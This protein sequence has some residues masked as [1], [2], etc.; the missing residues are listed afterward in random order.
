MINVSVIICTHNPRPDYLSRVLAAL[1]SQT[2]PMEQW[3]LLVIDNASQEPL[4]SASWDLSWHPRARLIREEELGLAMARMRGM[5]EAVAA[6]FVFVDDDN[7]LDPGYLA[8]AFR[9]GREWPQLGV[10]GGS[11]IHEYEIQPSSNLYEF[12]GALGLRDVKSPLWS[13][14]MTC[15]DALPI[16][17]GLCVRAAVGAAYA[18]HFG[19]AD[20]QL[21]GRR[22]ASLLSGEDFDMCYY[23]CHLGLGMGLFPQLK[24]T[25]LIPKE[26]LDKQYLVRLTEGI[27]IS[28]FLL[29]YKWL[30]IFPPSH[31]TGLGLLRFTR[32]FYRF[33][34]LRRRTYLAEVRAAKIAARMINAIRNTS[35]AS[36][37]N[38]GVVLPHKRQQ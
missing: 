20:V 13:N 12:V 21:G 2:L 19:K 29:R 10:W 36:P 11:V 16:G 35:T 37:V 15:S 18:E 8:E 28:L 23:V 5:R 38:S 32:N 27:H 9:I 3:E 31:I 33:R 30:G 7:V 1:R 24:V 17:A 6:L 34:G 22:G 14:V 4:T 26:R 25:H